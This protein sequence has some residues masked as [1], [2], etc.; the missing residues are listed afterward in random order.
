MLKF[1]EMLLK[2]EGSQYY[3]SLYLKRGYYHIQLT[4]DASNLC[5]II[6]PWVKYF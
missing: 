5:K 4:L 3:T 2:L 6:L 1:N